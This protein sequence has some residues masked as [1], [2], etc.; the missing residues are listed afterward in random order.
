M[1]RGGGLRAKKGDVH[2]TAWPGMVP[3]RVEAVGSG[4][5]KS[6]KVSGG[7]NEAK[8]SQRVSPKDSL[9]VSGGAE[10]CFPRIA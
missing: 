10:G 3:H 7:Q 8:R 2:C 5:E 4:F 9:F 1:A 6:H